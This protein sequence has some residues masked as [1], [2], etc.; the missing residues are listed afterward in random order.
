MSGTDATKETILFSL[1]KHRLLCQKGGKVLLH[2][3]HSPLTTGIFSAYQT[4]DQM[5]LLLDHAK[6]LLCLFLS[7]TSQLPGCRGI[8]ER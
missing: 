6:V 4:P 5:T 7:V 2:H 8:S 3:V 1:M